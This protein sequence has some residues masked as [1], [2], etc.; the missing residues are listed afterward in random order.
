MT[1]Y[2]VL[3]NG[4]I[5]QSYEWPELEHGVQGKNG[6]V[7]GR[8]IQSLFLI[9]INEHTSH[10]QAWLVVKEERKEVRTVGFHTAVQIQVPWIQII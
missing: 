2:K 1:Q 5:P 4:S 8:C 3:P 9:E 6:S 10:I 7:H